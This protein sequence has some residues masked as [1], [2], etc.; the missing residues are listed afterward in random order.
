MLVKE[1]Q[2]IMKKVDGAGKNCDDFML[3]A[4]CGSNNRGIR[5]QLWVSLRQ[6]GQNIGCMIWL[7]GEYFNIRVVSE[8][9]DGGQPEVGV[10]D[11]FNCCVRDC[12]LVEHPHTS[13]Q[14]F[15]CRN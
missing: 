12:E 13:S 6:A 10:I 14:F 7:V 11:E 15:W 3:S 1:D 4:V 8:S 5:M 2:H 9:V